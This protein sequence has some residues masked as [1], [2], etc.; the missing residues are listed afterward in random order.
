M[1]MLSDERL[2]EQFPLTRRGFA[3]VLSLREDNLR[4]STRRSAAL[5]P[6]QKLSI[7]M[8]VFGFASIQ[9]K[10]GY[11]QATVSM[12]I[13]EVSTT[14]EK[15]PSTGRMKICSRR[16]GWRELTTLCTRM[17]G[18][19]EVVGA[20]G[21]THTKIIDED[22]YVF[23]ESRIYREFRQKKETG[24]ILA[25]SAYGAES[26]LLKPI[27]RANRTPAEDRYTNA[28]CAG[29]AV[30]ERAIGALKHMSPNVVQRSL[31]RATLCAT[32]V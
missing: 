9:R 13:S 2:R 29:R 7:F 26:I 24:I 16:R 20:I 1:D 25:D 4:S 28:V 6:A 3:F 32:S 23:K 10:T 12:V 18:I 31:S 15:N 30:V 17:C 27:L 21:G 8:Y 14:G 11:S 22:F 5:T 19:P